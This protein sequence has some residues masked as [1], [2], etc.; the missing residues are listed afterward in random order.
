MSGWKDDEEEEDM[1]VTT[2]SSIFK[3]GMGTSCYIKETRCIQAAIV[4]A[5]SALFSQRGFMWDS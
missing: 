3:V 4:I 5:V 2:G 1:G